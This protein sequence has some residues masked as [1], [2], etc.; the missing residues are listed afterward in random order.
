[1]RFFAALTQIKSAN[2]IFKKVDPQSPARLRAFSAKSKSIAARTKEAA[3]CGG[4]AF[5]AVIDPCQ[6]VCSA[7]ATRSF[8][9]TTA[10]IAATA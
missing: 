9:R 3:N 2:Q 10:H 6:G 4:L 5:D 1:M 8:E 7:P